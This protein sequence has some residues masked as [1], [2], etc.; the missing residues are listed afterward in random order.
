MSGEIAKFAERGLWTD[1]FNGNGCSGHSWQ[2]SRPAS[3]SLGRRTILPKLGTTKKP[4]VFTDGW[5]IVVMVVWDTVGREGFL[6]PA[7]IRDYQETTSIHG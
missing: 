6:P 7:K 2:S 3:P 4:P 5:W 1:R